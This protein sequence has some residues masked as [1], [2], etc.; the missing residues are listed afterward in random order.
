[1][2][3]IITQFKLKPKNLFL[4]DGLG[5]LLTAFFL[6]VILRTFSEYFGM[7]QTTLTYLSVI[8]LF[9]FFYSFACFYLLKNDWKPF[10]R[11]ISIAN[12][13]YC[14]LTLG[15]VIYHRQSI[16][17]LGITYFFAEIILVCGLVFVELKTLKTES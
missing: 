6:F 9:F 2:E 4:I 17:L 7:P 3:K 14:I 16:T 1:M 11:I 10:L 12:L 8:A 15:L 13:L 5:A